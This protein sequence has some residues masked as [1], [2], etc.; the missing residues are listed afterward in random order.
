MERR[1]EPPPRGGGGRVGGH[2]P[3]PG[4]VHPQKIRAI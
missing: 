1:A 3:V 4:I 2:D